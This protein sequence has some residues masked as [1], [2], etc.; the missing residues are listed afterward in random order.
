MNVI[1]IDPAAASTGSA[2]DYTL[3]DKPTPEPANKPM[4]GWPN[5]PIP[6]LVEGKGGARIQDHLA[7]V[8]IPN[9]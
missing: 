3:G 4:L 1:S 9:E 7:K 6:E 2:S 8:E 5:K